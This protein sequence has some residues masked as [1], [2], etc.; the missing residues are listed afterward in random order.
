M[1]LSL[2][3]TKVPPLI[4]PSPPSNTLLITVSVPAQNI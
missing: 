3:L 2:D 1:N 4:T